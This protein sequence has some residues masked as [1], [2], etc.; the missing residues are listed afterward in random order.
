MIKIA[1]ISDIEDVVYLRVKQQIEDWNKTSLNKNYSKYELN[2]FQI[3]KKHILTRLNKSIYFALMYIK[4]TPVA[5]CGLE[6]L[7]ELPQIT[8]CEQRNSRSGNLVSVY[9]RPEH[10][11]KGYQQKLLKKL[12]EFAKFQRFA[13]ITLT[14]NT[15]NAKHIYEKLNFKYISDKY[16]MKF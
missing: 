7:N 12:L 16:Y 1:D 3:T 6:E 9:T 10:R 13:D 2:F 8:A 11:G 5:I 14:T 15:S 4:N